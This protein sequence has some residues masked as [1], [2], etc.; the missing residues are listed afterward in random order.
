MTSEY[1]E[2]KLLHKQEI[3]ELRPLLERHL[4][5]AQADK[6]ELQQLRSQVDTGFARL[7]LIENK[8]KQLVKSFEEKEQERLQTINLLKSERI[9]NRKLRDELASQKRILSSA[10][11]ANISHKKLIKELEEKL[12]SATSTL[13]TQDEELL[14]YRQESMKLQRYI[15]QLEE[16]AD[17]AVTER[18]AC[19]RQAKATESLHAIQQVELKAVQRELDEILKEG[20]TPLKKQEFDTLRRQLSNSKEEILQVREALKTAQQKIQ[21]LEVSKQVLSQQRSTAKLNA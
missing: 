11:A 6:A 12:S 9:L 13:E 20:F 16:T 1:E 4:L 7:T 15:K 18:D 8:N 2:L 17:A 19:Q 14:N 10:G 21:D 3:Q 5:Q